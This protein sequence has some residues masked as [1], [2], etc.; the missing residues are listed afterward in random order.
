[1]ADRLTRRTVTAR[2]RYW[3][4]RLGLGAWSIT[5]QYGPDHEEG[6]EA[7]CMAMPEYG[8]A[9]VQFDLKAIGP[10][11]LDSYITHELLHCYCWPLANAAHALCQGDAAKLEWVRTEEETLVTNLERLVG[12]LTAE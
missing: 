11:E 1:M 8:S 10:D 5:V 4:R 9:I 3:Q 6:S 2:V 7:S 12:R